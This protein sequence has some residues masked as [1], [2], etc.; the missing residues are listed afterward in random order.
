MTRTDRRRLGNAVWARAWQRQVAADD[1]TKA[2]SPNQ[3]LIGLLAR[4]AAAERTNDALLARNAELEAD[5]NLRD[6]EHRGLRGRLGRA[7][8]LL[9]HYGI[10]EEEII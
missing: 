10:N 9:Q 4:G 3:R 6:C 1:A 5:A 2:A 7:L 8:R